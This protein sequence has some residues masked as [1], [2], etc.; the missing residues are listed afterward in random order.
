MSNLLNQPLCATNYGNV[1]FGDC[2]LEPQ[3]I[4][5]GFQ[6]PSTLSLSQSDMGT[7]QAVLQTK[8]SAAIGTRIFPYSNWI[9]V[10]DNTEDV[11]ITT[12]D[13]GAKYINRDGFY[14]F[15]FRYLIGGVQLHNEIQKNAG[16]GKYFL[17]YD[18]KGNLFG[19]RGANNTLK[20]IKVDIFYANPWRLPTGADAA[21]YL[22][23]F[24]INPSELN[25]GN[26]AFYSQQD[27]SFGDIAG[28]QELELLLFS[29]ASNV[30]KVTIHTKISKVDL[31]PIYGNALSVVGYWKATKRSDGSVI[32]ITSIAEDA[33]NKAYTFTFNSGTVSG[34]AATDAILLQSQNASVLLAAGITPYEAHEGIYIEL[35]GS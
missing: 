12:T 35:P 23:R 9:S 7:L 13:Y 21:S 29:L 20:G 8:I 10:T 28:I 26:L 25:Y 5:G 30:A 27:F 11:S 3:E 4:V 16:S 22:L 1:G 18:K 15:S 24:I 2:F 6:V 19:K 34:M 14:D 33:P 17:F 32:S 31:H